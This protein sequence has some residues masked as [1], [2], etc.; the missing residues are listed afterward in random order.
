MIACA[1]L[2]S[3]VRETIAVSSS[4]G[5]AAATLICNGKDAGS[6]VT[7]VQFTI[8]R[9]AGDCN[10]HL[11][12]EG[13]EDV[14]LPI[15]QGVNPHFWTNMI[16]SPLVPGGAYVLYLGDSGESPIGGLMIATAAVVFST[17]FV[18]GAVHKH[19]PSHVDVVLK[20]KQ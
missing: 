7:P 17:D 2:T 15:E 3:G 5:G 18:T 12:K 14:T 11:S 13:F 6:G 20:P 10:L 8:R 4:P 1:T 16:F 9:N 19:R